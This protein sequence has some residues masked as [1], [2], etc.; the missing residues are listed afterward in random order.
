MSSV[1][2]NNDNILN[3]GSVFNDVSSV[4]GNVWELYW[5]GQCFVRL[6]LGMN[7]NYGA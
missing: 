3:S 4:N 5:D 2:L 7:N 6:L 1:G